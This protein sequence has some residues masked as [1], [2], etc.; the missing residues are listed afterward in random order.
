M[1]P[2]NSPPQ[3]VVVVG[4]G[5]V[6]LPV[7]IQCANRGHRVTGIDRDSTVLERIAA[8]SFR[9]DDHALPRTKEATPIRLSSTLDP[10][11]LADVVI[12]CV[13]LTSEICQVSPN[14]A[15][16]GLVR[17]IILRVQSGAMILMEST[18]PPGFSESFIMPTIRERGWAPGIDLFYAHCPERFN[19]GDENWSTR[20]IPRVIGGFESAS[21][22]RAISFY[23]TILTS[24]IVPVPGI[25]EAEAVKVFENVF[26]D[27]N[28]ALVN[29]LAVC[30]DRMKI[31]LMAVIRAA[32][33]KPFGFLPHYPSCGVG[34]NCI[35]V[36]PHLMMAAAAA[37]GCKLE[38]LEQSRRIN[39]SMPSYTVSRLQE[40]L[41]QAG[42]SLP[43]SRVG[44]LGLSYK[45]NVG[46]SRNSPALRIRQELVSMGAEVITFDP[47]LPAESD[48]NGLSDLLAQV[49]M[50][51]LTVGHRELVEA[52]TPE[53]LQQHGI[54][55]I[56]DGANGLNPARFERSS[57]T[58]VGIGQKAGNPDEVA[59]SAP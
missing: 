36:A 25:R 5:V 41:I 57:V 43:G 9:T 44:L 15:L 22:G 47:L 42:L 2:R 52:L 34:G 59:H 38:L 8:G 7:A 27:I 11:A 40:A 20:N 54:H 17:D 39:E 30:F 37:A 53:N 48:T 13:P 18:I 14:S 21:I 19:P 10:V 56:I 16:E 58:Y 6:G 55:V 26:R 33:T 1:N 50:V 51:I 46:D 35:P 32:S 45:A 4:L 28:I 23:N 49:Q 24:N 12:I 29:E 31:D 3:G